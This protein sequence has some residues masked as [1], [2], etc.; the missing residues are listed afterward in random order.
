MSFLFFC[1]ALFALAT[2][3]SRVNRDVSLPKDFSILPGNERN[4]TAKPGEHTF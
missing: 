3:A 2:G 1:W 4:A